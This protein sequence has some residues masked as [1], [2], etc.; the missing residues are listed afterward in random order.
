M[1]GECGAGLVVAVGRKL[2][3]SWEACWGWE[4]QDQRLRVFKI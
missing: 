2:G 3:D 4:P 1:A